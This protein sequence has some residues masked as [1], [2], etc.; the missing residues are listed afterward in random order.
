MER[1]NELWDE[2]LFFF[3]A[4][5]V[6]LLGVMFPFIASGKS[7]LSTWELDLG[8][9]FI[10]N[11]PGQTSAQINISNYE[12][13]QL[14]QTKGP[15]KLSYYVG[16]RTTIVS[17][18]DSHWLNALTLGL[19]NYYTNLQT[20]GSVNQYQAPWLNNYTYNLRSTMD[21]LLLELQMK[22][23]SVYRLTPFVS[24]GTGPGFGTM[25]YH[26][27]PNVGVTEGQNQLSTH[28]QTLWAF[29]IGAGGAYALTEKIGVTLQYLY[30]VHTNQLQSQVCGNERCLLQP[31]QT[32]MNLSELMVSLRY[33]F[34]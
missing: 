8:L 28:H 24:F 17:T 27:T 2:I 26:E 31:L 15:T 33:Q 20:Q 13:D 18:P 19:S 5:A 16:S 25:S 32:D 11:S 1:R 9:G 4:L 23:R 29:E 22:L 10:L 14:V 30:I 12:I 3:K 34:G 21:D 7:S 6:G